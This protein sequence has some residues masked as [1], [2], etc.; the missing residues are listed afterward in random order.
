MTGHGKT[1]RA[2]KS[3]KHT[4]GHNQGFKIGHQINKEKGGV[5]VSITT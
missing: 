3:I 4:S 2:S 5:D 1:L